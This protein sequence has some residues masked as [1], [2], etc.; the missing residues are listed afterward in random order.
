MI[1]SQVAQYCHDK[2]NNT[3]R[4]YLAGRGVSN[5]F[6]EAFGLGFSPFEVEDMVSVLGRDNLLKAGVIFESEGEKIYSLIR[7]TIT[8]PF[9]NH[10]GKVVSVSFRPIQSNEVIKNKN[11]RKY[12]HITFTKG[13]FLYGINRARDAIREQKVAIAVEGQFDV[14]VSH[15]FG[16]TNT[17]GVVGSALT[18]QQIKLIS[19]ST[20]N[21]IV[22]FDGDEAG[23]KASEKVRLIETEGLTIKTARLPDG[24]DVDSFLQSQGEEAYRELLNSA[25]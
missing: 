13:S 1:L 22:V 12:W 5:E 15:Q 7:N 21:L 14:I 2:L 19:R 20:K 6:I 8:F 25:V 23:Q 24:D 3:A 9:I 16:F 17:V 4:Q 11:L 10:H 18:A